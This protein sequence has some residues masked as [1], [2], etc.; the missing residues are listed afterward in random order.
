MT[1]HEFNNQASQAE[2]REVLRNDTYMARQ[3]NTVDDVG[4]RFAKLTPATVTGSAPSPQYP[5]LPEGS[6]WAKGFDQNVEPPIG[7]D[8]NAQ[9][10]V[11]TTKEQ[12]QSS[13]ALSPA[14]AVA[15]PAEVEDRV[16]GPVAEVASFPASSAA[17]SPSMKR[18]W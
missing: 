17:G 4:G 16:K 11:G 15:S 9:E 8:V 1:T 12:E 18:R 14:T 2:R 3:Q 7:F 5:Q 13:L 10:A 6:P